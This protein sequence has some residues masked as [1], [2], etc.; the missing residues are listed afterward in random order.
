[1]AHP[2]HHAESSARRFGGRPEDCLFLGTL[3]HSPCGGFAK[4]RG[5]QR[6]ATRP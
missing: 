2:W 4:I 6:T 5:E 1:M 3:C